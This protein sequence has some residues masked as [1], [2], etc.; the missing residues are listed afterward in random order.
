[1]AR[2]ATITSGVLNLKLLAAKLVDTVLPA[3]CISCRQLT[4]EPGGLCFECWK[5]LSFIEHPLCERTGIPFAFDPGEG[6]VSARALAQPPVWT[7]A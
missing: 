5:Q 2:S 6:I 4:S 7:R 3:Q 1:M